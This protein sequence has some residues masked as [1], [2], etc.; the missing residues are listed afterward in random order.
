MSRIVIV[1]H[2]NPS[3]I[4]FIMNDR[5]FN[6]EQYQFSRKEEPNGPEATMLRV[7]NTYTNGVVKVEPGRNAM[8]VEIQ[9][10][11]LLS[12]V[13]PEILIAIKAFVGEKDYQPEIFVDERR[14]VEQPV[15]SESENNWGD[16]RLITPGVKAKPGEVDIGVPYGVW[17]R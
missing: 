13:V 6:Q 5:M 8:R 9:D 16:S 11:F 1:L 7:L 12:E 14:F 2:P 10:G 4:E 15:Y 17:R 3:Y